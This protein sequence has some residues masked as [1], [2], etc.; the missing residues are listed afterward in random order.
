M[1]DDIVKAEPR[2][3]MAAGA[4]LAEAL[5]GAFAKLGLT[6]QLMELDHRMREQADAHYKLMALAA[7]VE[8]TYDRLEGVHREHMGVMLDV[9]R[10]QQSRAALEERA[11]QQG[12]LDAMG[13][14]RNAAWG[15]AR[16]EA[17]LCPGTSKDMLRCE[18]KQKHAGACKFPKETPES[19][20]AK[21]KAA[22]KP[23]VG[24]PWSYR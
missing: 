9:Q 13:Y 8:Q 16:L 6:E 4:S 14:E 12:Y 3:A 20:A 19:R 1:S 5:A 21:E 11:R 17:G 23:A 2:D 15:I 7:K 24:A 22:E 18:L 10:Q